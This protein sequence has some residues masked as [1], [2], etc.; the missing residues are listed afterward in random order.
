MEIE[1]SH[2]K[3]ANKEFLSQAP[4]HVVEDVREKS[5][6]MAVKLEKLHQNLT[7]I[8]EVS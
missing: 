2:M 7:L 4:P 8:E 5:E 1:R 6:L 3:L